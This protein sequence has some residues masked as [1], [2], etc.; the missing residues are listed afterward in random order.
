MEKRTANGSNAMT[1]FYL[2]IAFFAGVCV[3]ALL[4]ACCVVAKRAD[5][6]LQQYYQE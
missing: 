4:M 6:H 5:A 3:G 2:L 1:L